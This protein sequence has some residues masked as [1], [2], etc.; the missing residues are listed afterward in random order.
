[1][2]CG[3]QGLRLVVVG[4]SRIKAG[5]LE[6]QAPDKDEDEDGDER[7]QDVTGDR[8]KREKDVGNEGKQE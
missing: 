7:A 8:D 5:G 3:D 6:N 1:M 2:R 4:K